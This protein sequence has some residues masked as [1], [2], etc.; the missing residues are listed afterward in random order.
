MSEALTNEEAIF[1]AAL[2]I[3]VAEQRSAY[4][5]SVCGNQEELRRRVE[6]LLRRYAEA[7]GPLDRP[8]LS[9][10]ATT[11][12]PTAERPGTVIGPYKLLEQIGEGGF[13][14]VFMAEQTQPMRRKVAVKVL[15]PGMETRQVV[16]RFEAERQALALMD[17]PNIAQVF[18]GGETATGR[19]YFVME[20]VRGIP[21][22]DFCDQNQLPI[23]ER[24]E[25]FEDVCQAV[26]HA[27]QK[28]I[29]HRD[30]KP[31][32]VLVT[33][34]DD[35]AVVKVI[36]FGIAKATGAQ[37]TDNTLFTNF[38]QMMGTPLYM[39]P[40]QAHMSGLD[41][42]TRSDI[43]ALGVLLYE[44][45]TGTTPFDK[46]RLG[47]VGYDEIRRIIREEEPAKPSTRISTLGQ[48]AATVSTQRKCDPKR[49]SQLCRGELDWI[50]MKALEK[51][52]NRRYE[53]AS[54]FAADVQRY[55]HDE[56]VQA[57]PP[58]TWYRLRKFARR[59]KA[60]LVTTAALVLAVLVALGS[61]VSAVRVLAASN[62]EIKEEQAQTN[63][64]FGREKQANDKL[65]QA[66]DREKQANDKLERILYFQRIG[67]AQHELAANDLGRAEELLTECPT[68]L[69]GWEWHYL[70]RYP[71]DK[72]RVLYAAKGSQYWG[73][74]TSADGHYLA[75][76]NMSKEVKLF[77]AVSGKE[78]EPLR[79]HAG[80]VGAVAFSPQGGQLATGGIDKHVILWDVATRKVIRK[81]PVQQPIMALAYRP[82]G[83]QLA[84]AGKD[85]T[86]RVWNLATGEE[87]LTIAGHAGMGACVAF[88]PDSRRLAS[89]GPDFEVR[90]CDANTGQETKRLAG[91]RLFISTLVF[92]QDGRHLL[93]GGLDGVRIWDL[94]TGQ[95]KGGQLNNSSA[96][97]AAFSPD[98]E[99]LVT[100]GWDKTVK[101]WD[102]R[103]GEEVLALAGH[104]DVLSAVAF[105]GDS[106]LVSGSV[107]GTLR[108]WNAAPLADNDPRYGRKLRGHHL[109]VLGLAFS[110]DSRYLLTGSA[111]GT[112]KLWEVPAGKLVHTLADH[113]TMIT[114]AAFYAG[115]NLLTTV[116]AD[117]T[118]VQWDP[119]TGQR[120]RTL[121]RQ[122]G[123][124]LGFGFRAAFSADGERFASQR[125]DGTIGVIETASGRELAASLTV[126]SVSAV[127]SPDGKQLAAANTLLSGVHLLDVESGKKLAELPD[128]HMILFLAFS[129]DGQRLAG[130]RWDG[131][132]RVWDLP[133]KKALHTFHHAD[134]ALCVAFH[135]DGRQ[136]ASGSWDNTAK[137]WDLETGKEVETLRGH[138]GYVTSVAYSPDGK[139]L[140]TASGHRC[141][142]EV[143]LW[144]TATFGKKR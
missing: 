6:A 136:L 57:C 37:L 70:K 1:H 67:L 35:K 121:R 125:K 140:A 33:L 39:S 53:S 41:I 123:P 135:P 87:V 52:R 126:A 132:V 129:A 91:H 21:I 90:I 118:L 48:A 103:S 75:A 13:G 117:G 96:A 122:L 66:L 30:L 88:S 58:S 62:A 60:A 80:M 85:G 115:G 17:H 10:A 14:I 116:T 50:V 16:A 108:L 93:S 107:D 133:S 20:L 61:L 71:H 144:E 54:A 138:I 97:C 11:D 63:E 45:L 134:R 105:S 23:R 128:S 22:T 100:G 34:H 51:D 137:I 26:Q 7:E 94:Q 59:H 113:D 18:D 92:H 28:G 120:R 69:R 46:E 25:L 95:E 44:L 55:L 74:A 127:L 102:W 5:E 47:A 19:P 43:Y 2:E 110:P 78:L 124:G 36:D 32:N 40:E 119:A 8:V 24:L 76:G 109:P 89:C 83:K 141:A 31:S 112:A 99:R 139:L 73:L 27:H 12:E 65:V 131:T 142:G 82:D 106:R 64:A 114:S 143:Q 77:D 42:D 130:A 72:P 84:T 49:L 79:E 3:D 56:P 98:G 29:I 101:V 4:L 9:L 86:V 15:K 104:T 38:A 111:D 68:K 81:L